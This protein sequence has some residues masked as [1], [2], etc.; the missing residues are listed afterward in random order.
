MYVKK[1][2]ILLGKP[3]RLEGMSVVVMMMWRDRITTNSANAERAKLPVVTRLEE[4]S[5]VVANIM[6]QIATNSAN[7]K[8]GATSGK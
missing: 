8:K 7:A 2:T 1:V 6:N 4:M 3:I 5:V